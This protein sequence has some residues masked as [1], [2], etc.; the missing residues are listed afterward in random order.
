MTQFYPQLQRWVIWEVNFAY[1]WRKSSMPV[2]QPLSCLPLFVPTS[3]RASL[4]G[5]FSPKPSGNAWKYSCSRCP[6]SLLRGLYK[7]EAFTFTDSVTTSPAWQC[8]VLFLCTRSATARCQKRLS[9]DLNM[10]WASRALIYCPSGR[11]SLAI[12]S[13]VPRS[14]STPSSLEV[15]FGIWV[16]SGH[17]AAALWGQMNEKGL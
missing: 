15:G 7:C 10:G 6:S 9:W 5:G 4:I 1:P 16:C 12:S 3:P 2:F 14:S 17:M 8:L 11:L 13:M